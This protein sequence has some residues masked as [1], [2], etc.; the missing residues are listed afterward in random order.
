MAMQAGQLD[1]TKSQ[2]FTQSCKLLPPLPPPTG[3]ELP[4]LTP[5]T[6]PAFLEDCGP[7]Q[8]TCKVE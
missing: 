4:P 5:P 2:C 1:E 6:L 7:D 8:W 3:A